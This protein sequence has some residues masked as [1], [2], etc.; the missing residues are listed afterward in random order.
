MVYNELRKYSCLRS[1]VFCCFLLPSNLTDNITDLTMI[2]VV[3]VKLR[4]D[5]VKNKKTAIVL[6]LYWNK[7]QKQVFTGLYIEDKYFDNGK[8]V[9]HPNAA[10]YNQAIKRKTDELEKHFL[11]QYVA[12]GEVNINAKGSKVSRM[13]FYNYGL[14][15]FRDKIG[16]CKEDYIIRC[17]YRLNDFKEFAGNVSFE[18]V[19]PQVL[20][21]YEQHLYK[22]GIKR[23]TINGR[24]KKIKEVFHHAVR[25]KVTDHDPFHLYSAP[26][27]KQSLRTHLTLDE[28]RQIETA[29]MDERLHTVRDFFL[30]CCHVGLRYSDAS[31]IETVKNK[32][33]ERLILETKKGDE[34]VSI[35]V[36]P[37]VKA[38]IKRLKGK[39]LPTNQKV[40]EYL[41]LIGNYAELDKVLTFHVAR[42][43]FAVNAASAG[44]PME[45]VQR[46]LGHKSIRSTAIYYKITDTKLDEAMD[47]LESFRTA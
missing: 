28:I 20:K 3:H 16:T 24:M 34:V 1:V 41:K 7:Q 18:G 26:T 36:T 37:T 43:S 39:K 5:K 14:K 13:S 32:G 46:L 45:V 2:P 21:D 42:H 9:K 12:K 6:Q 25:A 17:I 47:K 31:K 33:V 11:D 40:N 38:I 44:L 30:L 23:N 27:Y 8:I 10:W 22:K 29:D 35:K 15:Y 19:T 4:K